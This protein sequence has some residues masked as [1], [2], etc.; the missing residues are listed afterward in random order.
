M[1][2][3]DVRLWSS[4]DLPAVAELYRGWGYRSAAHSRDVLVVAEHAGRIVG[5]VRLVREHGHTLLRG[6]R[7]QPEFQR[8]GVGTRMLRLF[9]QQLSG[10]CYCIPFS[11]LLGFYGQV[12]FREIAEESAPAFLV[13]RVKRYRAEGPDYTIMHRPG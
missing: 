2:D 8:G 9:V 10:D 5:V 4:R 6:M 3:V 7:V 13:E 12:G 1:N 11:H